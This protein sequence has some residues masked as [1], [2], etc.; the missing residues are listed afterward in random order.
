MTI[1]TSCILAQSEPNLAAIRLTIMLFVLVGGCFL[2]YISSS[3]FGVP[4]HYA[5]K[6]MTFTLCTFD[7]LIILFVIWLLQLKLQLVVLP[8]FA[9]VLMSIITLLSASFYHRSKN[10]EDKSKITLTLAGGISN[11]GYT[12]GAFVCYGLF[13]LQALGLAQLYLMFWFPLVFIVFFPLLK[14]REIRTS[15]SSSKLRVYHILDPRMM[16]V[17]AALVAV[18]LNLTKV[19]VPSFI[20]RFHII[21]IL[22][23]TS[24]L[25]TF[26]SIGLRV[27]LTRIRDYFRNYYPVLA[28][29]FLL[30]P[31]IAFALLFMVSIFSI[32]LTELARNVIII[33]SFSPCGV[34][35]VTMS[36]VF[37]LDG[38]LASAVWVASTVVYVIIIVPILCL[39]FI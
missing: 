22:V 17:P 1:C 4:E 26:Y 24:S 3:R 25:L 31:A 5:K 20:T 10:A 28:I 16:L 12:G 13:G 19:S 21:D 27:K 11:I 8:V 39:L 29:K 36:N 34:M 30:T 2:G 14:I 37:N 32:T 38:P 33:L 9:V 6:I 18:V 15:D 7:W 23:F 35:M